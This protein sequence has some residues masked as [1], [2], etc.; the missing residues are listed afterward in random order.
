MTRRYRKLTD[1]QWSRASRVREDGTH[2]HSIKCC[3][4]GLVHT[5]QYEITAR[6][7]LRFRAWRMNHKVAHKLVLRHNRATMRQ[8]KTDG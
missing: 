5:V 4:C 2:V 6:G 8:I 3:D 1:G 7:G